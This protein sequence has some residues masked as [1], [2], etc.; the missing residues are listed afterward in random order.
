MTSSSSA[1]E[2]ASI[3]TAIAGVLCSLIAILL[4]GSTRVLDIVYFAY[5]LRGAIFVVLLLGI[6]WKKTS[7]K[8]AIYGMVC[9]GIVGVFWVSYRAIV[10]TFPIHPALSET[11]VSVFVAGAA[12]YLFSKIYPNNKPAAAKKA[13][14]GK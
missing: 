3:T 5:S 10:G 1:K 9:T 6:Y 7:S 11:Y 8:G 2:T 12:T 4:Y 13:G 14:G